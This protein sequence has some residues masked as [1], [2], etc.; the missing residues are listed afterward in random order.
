[1]PRPK[2]TSHDTAAVSPSPLT[3]TLAVPVDR[4]L[5]PR[6]RAAAA[7]RGT[8]VERLATSVLETVTQDKLFDAVLDTDD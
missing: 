1:M 7:A 4:E 2:Q 8:T 6:L 5:V 3:M